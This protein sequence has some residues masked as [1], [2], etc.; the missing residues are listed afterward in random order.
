MK[1]HK[2]IKNNFD[3]KIVKKLECANCAK[4]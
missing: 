3:I 1:H 4:L 2:T